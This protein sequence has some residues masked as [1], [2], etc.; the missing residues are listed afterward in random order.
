[1]HFPKP[2]LLRKGRVLEVVRRNPKVRCD[3]VA[4]HMRA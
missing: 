4:N 2:T 3:M 1:M